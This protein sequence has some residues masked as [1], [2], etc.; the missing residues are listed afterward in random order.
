MKLLIVKNILKKN[1]EIL[2]NKS[3][4]QLIEMEIIL[5]KLSQNN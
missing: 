4:G 3:Y 5:Q 2:Q 1:T